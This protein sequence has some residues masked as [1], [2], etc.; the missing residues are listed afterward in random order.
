MLWIMSISLP[1]QPTM[2]CI[3]FIDFFNHRLNIPLDWCMNEEVMSPVRTCTPIAWSHL[4]LYQIFHTFL[5][6]YY[7]APR[8]SSHHRA[9][10]VIRVLVQDK[11]YTLYRQR[12]DL[13][14]DPWRIPW[15]AGEVVSMNALCRQDFSYDG[16]P[17]CIRC[18][19]YNSLNDD[20]NW[21]GE[22]RIKW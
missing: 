21:E 3:T 10:V 7:A 11:E 22:G 16:G 13:H 15:Q 5:W 6:Y 4:G 17:Y 8:L 20:R 18:G 2:Y 14:D 1:N 12:P 19:R 9:D